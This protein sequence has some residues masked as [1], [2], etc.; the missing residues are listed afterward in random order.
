MVGL[1]LAPMSMSPS[2]KRSHDRVVSQL[3]HVAA[4]NRALTGEALRLRLGLVRDYDRLY[5]HMRNLE[6]SVIDLGLLLEPGDEDWAPELAAELAGLRPSI[7]HLT[8]LVESFPTSNA[9]FLY[10]LRA[11]PRIRAMLA[12]STEGALTLAQEEMYLELLALHASWNAEDAGFFLQRHADL[13]GDFRAQPGSVEMLLSHSRVSVE[14]RLEA[15]A[16]LREVQRLSDQVALDRRVPDFVALM[17]EQLARHARRKSALQAA[18]YIIALGICSA[19]TI[20]A[21]RMARCLTD[22]MAES[23]RLS[24]EAK[25]YE[26]QLRHAQKLESI[27]QL[28]AGI[29]HEINTPAQYVSDNTQFLREAFDELSPLLNKMKELIDEQDLKNESLGVLAEDV[30]LGYLCDEVPRS[31]GQS[32]DGIGRITKIVRAMKEFSHPGQDGKTDA[33]LNHNIESTVTVAENEW[34][35]VADMELDLDESLPPV[36]CLVSEINQVVLNV[37]IN[38]AHAIGDHVVEGA[39]GRITVQTRAVDGLVEIRI[40]DTGGGIPEEIKQRIFDPFFTTKEV[41]KGTGQGLA[42]AHNVI[43]QKHGGTI[44]VETEPGKGTT[45]ILRLPLDMAHASEITEAA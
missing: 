9:T 29:A 27:G 11:L 37:V 6:H 39:K 41:G 35:Y 14:Q 30:E 26:V 4:C 17:H 20:Q 43:V 19:L 44:D 40:S 2:P 5:L 45:F 13:L 16:I 38:A 21:T 33:D 7:D 31:I 22:E 32:I 34:K 3:Q 23:R 8:K 28:A 1:T 25:A 18:C 42:I 15:D 24:E 36:P 10:S 12:S